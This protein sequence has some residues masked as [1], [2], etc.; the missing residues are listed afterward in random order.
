MGS[1]HVGWV[2]VVH[3]AEADASKTETE[4]WVVGHPKANHLKHLH[5]VL[6]QGTVP[7]QQRGRPHLQQFS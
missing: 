6:G 5:R 7:C 1:K 2:A 3:A 4:K